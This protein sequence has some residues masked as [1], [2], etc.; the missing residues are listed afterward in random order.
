MQPYTG[1]FYFENRLFRSYGNLKLLITYFPPPPTI[2]GTGYPHQHNHQNNLARRQFRFVVKI[3]CVLCYL[4]NLKF[5]WVF[6]EIWYPHHF[7]SQLGQPKSDCFDLVCADQ[8]RYLS[9]WEPRPIVLFREGLRI[10][11]KPKATQIKKTHFMKYIFIP[12]LVKSLSSGQ[13]MSLL[14]TF[15][16]FIP[17]I[18][19]AFSTFAL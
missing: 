8:T 2:P 5:F 18:K 3:C 11:W 6:G 16:Y 4:K 17:T 19:H 15:F 14:T 13:W 9:I 10:C 7:L 12:R 1:K